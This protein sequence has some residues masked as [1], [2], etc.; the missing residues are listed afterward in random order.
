MRISRGWLLP[1]SVARAMRSPVGPTGSWVAKG[2]AV[3]SRVVL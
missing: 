1:W 3:L 2:L